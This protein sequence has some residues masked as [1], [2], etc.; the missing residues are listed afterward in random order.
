MSRKRDRHEEVRQF[1]R[2]IDAQISPE[3]GIDPSNECMSPTSNAISEK[4]MENKKVKPVWDPQKRWPVLKGVEKDE[5]WRFDFGESVGL[6]VFGFWYPSIGK[7]HF[8]HAGTYD[9]PVRIKFIYDR[10]ASEGKEEEWHGWN[11]PEWLKCAKELEQEGVRAIVCGCGLTGTMQSELANA[12][13]IPIFTSTILFVP[14]IYRTLRKNLKVGILTVSK[15]AITRWDNLLLRECGVDETIPIVIAGMTE[16]D[17]CDTWWSQLDS[18]F[19]QEEVELSMIK[20]AQKMV[21]DDPSVGAIVCEC[22]DMAPYSGAIAKATGLPV[23]DAA[24]MVKFVNNMVT[25]STRLN[26][27]F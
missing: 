17:S 4:I 25:P 20:A 22:T 21:S 18:G 3:L 15:E 7:G 10:K 12:V 11:I 13:S 19:S 27:V 9:F 8:S 16:S 23:F 14:M 24:D 6:I 2:Q 5:D 1:L 26:S